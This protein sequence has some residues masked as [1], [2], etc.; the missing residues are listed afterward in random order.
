MQAPFPPARQIE[1]RRRKRGGRTCGPLRW[2]AGIARVH[3]MHAPKDRLGILAWL[4]PHSNGPCSGFAPDSPS[5]SAPAVRRL[6]SLCNCTGSIRN[7][8]R[9]SDKKCP[10][11]II[12]RRTSP[13][14]SL[15]ARRMPRHLCKATKVI[16]YNSFSSIFHL[17]R[18]SRS[19]K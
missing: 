5:T 12:Q 7:H 10:H 16:M 3:S 2:Q 4:A 9:D 6:S 8:C 17:R 15:Q 18:L 19:I 14:K 11:Y 1:G 13:T